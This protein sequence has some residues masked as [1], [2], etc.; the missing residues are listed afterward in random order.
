M[1]LTYSGLG[2]WS[3]LQGFL[4]QEEVERAERML[5]YKDKSGV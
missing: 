3:D 2:N 5:V 4:G 1:Y